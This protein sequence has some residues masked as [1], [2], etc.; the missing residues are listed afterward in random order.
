M[1]YAKHQSPGQLVEQFP[2]IIENLK[3]L[4]FEDDYALLRVKSEYAT[5]LVLAQRYHQA[6]VVMESYID[7]VKRLCLPSNHFY[8]LQL[9]QLGKLRSY[10][11]DAQLGWS[12]IRE[13]VDH[14]KAMLGA[15]HPLV[16]EANAC[17]ML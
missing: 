3:S 8:F 5:E 11:G 10:E 15:S 9:Y 13:A 12:L 16:H 6:R 14:L 17:M 1:M 4:F 2:V 7:A